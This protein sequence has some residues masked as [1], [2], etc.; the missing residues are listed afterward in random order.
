M[1]SISFPSR[2]SRLPGSLEQQSKIV[3][4]EIEQQKQEFSIRFW[5]KCEYDQ[6]QSGLILGLET[7]L[8]GPAP[9]AL[10]ETDDTQTGRGK[11]Y[12]SSVILEIS[13]PIKEAQ[14]KMYLYL[15]NQAQN[16]S[17]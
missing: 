16:I 4:E 12:S 8:S 7:Q 13:R 6:P 11:S 9:A 15:T 17:F 14:L 3:Q 1:V 2:A 5:D 10:L